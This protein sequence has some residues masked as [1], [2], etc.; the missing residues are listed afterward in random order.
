M[1][2]RGTLARTTVQV[3]AAKVVSACTAPTARRSWTTPTVVLT[4]MTRRITAQSVKSPV[5]AVSTAA[6]SKT[7]II[8]SRSS[9]T[10]ERTSERGGSVGTVLSPTR[11]RRRTASSSV[12]PLAGST[13]NARA[14][15]GVSHANAST[16]GGPSRASWVGAVMVRSPRR[17]V[18]RCRAGVGD[19]LVRAEAQVVDDGDHAFDPLDE[20]HRHLGVQA[21]VELAG[22]RDH[23]AVDL[24]K[25]TGGVGAE[26]VE[27]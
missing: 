6:A 20:A 3:G 2:R 1:V 17:S 18:H 27:Q 13:A 25:D 23:A 16:H 21:R 22:D 8:V 5:T 14:T 26:V 9:A 7:R 10:T 12:R 11:A 24:E 19:P 15:A 4:A